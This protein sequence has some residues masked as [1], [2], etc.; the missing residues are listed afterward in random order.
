LLPAGREILATKPLA[1]GSLTGTNTI[2]IVLVRCFV[3]G[4]AVRFLRAG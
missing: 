4:L 1:T 2:E 3:G